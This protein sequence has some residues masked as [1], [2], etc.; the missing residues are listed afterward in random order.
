MLDT[1]GAITGP[2]LLLIPEA[3]ILFLY[4]VSFKAFRP[5]GPQ[6]QRHRMGQPWVVAP[7]VNSFLHYHP[8]WQLLPQ[9]P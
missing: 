1:L 7:W 8:S 5:G 4:P 6:G 3:R 2:P 9:F